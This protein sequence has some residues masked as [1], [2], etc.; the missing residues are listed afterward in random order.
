[1]ILAG[2]SRFIIADLT[3]PKSVPQELF[4]IIPH[5]TI[6]V[7]PLIEKSATPFAMFAHFQNYNWVLNPTVYVG[8]EGVS[9]LVDQITASAEAKISEQ[10]LRLNNGGT[11]L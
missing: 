11:D 5:F 9:K 10:M 8:I 6:P 4:Q 2:L 3:N 1:M 7:V